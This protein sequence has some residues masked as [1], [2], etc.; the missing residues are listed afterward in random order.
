MSL[1]RA[2]ILILFNYNDLL[3]LIVPV[4]NGVS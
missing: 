4:V 3:L 2:K 1:N